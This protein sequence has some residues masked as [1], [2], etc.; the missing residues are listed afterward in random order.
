MM[1]RAPPEFTGRYLLSMQL[2][3][4][5][6]V[7]LALL[8]TTA[9]LVLSASC[10]PRVISVLSLLALMVCPRHTQEVTRADLPDR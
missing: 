7:V 2:V 4:A 5:A 3:T 8:A 9:E 6:D 1:T 10:T